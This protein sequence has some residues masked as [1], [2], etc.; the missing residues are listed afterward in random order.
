MKNQQM[1]TNNTFQKEW[2]EL[3]ELKAQSST[4]FKEVDKIYGLLNSLQPGDK[5][6]LIQ[7]APRNRSFFFKV[8]HMYVSECESMEYNLS[9]RY[10]ERMRIKPSEIIQQ[11]NSERNAKRINKAHQLEGSSNRDKGDAD[12]WFESGGNRKKV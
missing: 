5:I 9:C 4:F 11:I 7:I 10:I 3:L 2:K 1:E 12:Q 6:Y 8:A